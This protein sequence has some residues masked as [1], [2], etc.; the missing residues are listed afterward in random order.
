VSD[1]NHEISYL[2][3]ILILAENIKLLILIPFCAA[4]IVFCVGYFKPQTYTSEAIFSVT[5]PASAI[6]MERMQSQ[7]VLDKVVSSFAMFKGMP[8][9]QARERLIDQIKIVIG[10]DM[11]LIL[12]VTTDNPEQSKSLSIAIV[13]EWTRSDVFGIADRVDLEKRLAYAKTGLDAVNAAIATIKS[14][15]KIASNNSFSTESASSLS[16]SLSEMQI[17]YLS[18]LVN[19]YRELQGVSHLNIKQSATLPAHADARDRGGFIIRTYFGVF[20]FLVLFLFARRLWVNCGKN[21]EIA[22]KQALIKKALGFK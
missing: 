17:K 2:D 16:Q 6:A 21:S 1:K 19:I 3:L 15:G 4:L 18:D 5:G 22:E 12:E 8:T 10:K 7:L 20:I 13:E 11:L 14:S 9:K